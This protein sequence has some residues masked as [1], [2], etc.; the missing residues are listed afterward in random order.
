MQ[1]KDDPIEHEN[2]DN[3]RVRDPVIHAMLHSQVQAVQPNTLQM[4]GNL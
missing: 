1:Q 2:A 3:K 4:Q